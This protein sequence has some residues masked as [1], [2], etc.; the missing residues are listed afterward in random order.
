MK[1]KPMGDQVLVKR[2]DGQEKTKSGKFK[3]D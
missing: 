2:Q 3:R 1:M